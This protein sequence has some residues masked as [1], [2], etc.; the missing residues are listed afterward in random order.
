MPNVNV[1]II[2]VCQDYKLVYDLRVSIWETNYLYSF[3]FVRKIIQGW[4]EFCCMNYSYL[5]KLSE[6]RLKLHAW[7][8][9]F[10]IQSVVRDT[11]NDDRVD[12]RIFLKSDSNH[13]IKTTNRMR[14]KANMMKNIT[15]F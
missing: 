5:F 9:Q 8:S 13:T 6:V 12:R 11:W 2:K 7:E 10:R 4:F 15:W 1:K 14:S 3:A